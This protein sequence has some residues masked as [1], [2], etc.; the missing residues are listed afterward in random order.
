MA[1][2]QGT[3]PRPENKRR[4]RL[5]AVVALVSLSAVAAG[6]GLWRDE[7]V[8]VRIFG[9]V[10][11]V[12]DAATPREPLRVLVASM[13]STR[14]TLELYGDII[15]QLG[16]S[17]GRRGIVV[18]RRNYAEGNEAI[19]H[20]EVDLAFV[21]SG[22]F[23]ES[24]SDGDY[25]ELLVVPVIGGKSTYHAYVIVAADSPWQRLEDLRGRSVAYVDADSLTGRNYLRYR[26]QAM[27][28]TEDAFFSRFVYTGSHDRS[29]EAVARG[30]VD[31]ASVDHLIFQMMIAQQPELGR[32][33][34]VIEQSPPF[35]APPVVVP[36]RLDPELRA[37][38]LTALLGLHKTPGGAALLGQLRVNR[39]EAVADAHYE[40]VRSLWAKVR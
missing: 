27:G 3:A 26:V 19:R 15:R 10:E 34:R 23:V 35:G 12:T 32:K 17:V 40:S 18:Q 28:G 11:P 5:V 39:F 13:A 24:Q 6:V 33:V 29:V 37:R 31:V 38:L 16:D 8:D 25:A 14:P 7:A 22:A 9:P 2:Q 4:W 36:R 30:L 1:A 21:C 20:G